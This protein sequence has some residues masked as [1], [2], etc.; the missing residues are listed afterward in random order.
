[1]ELR[2]RAETVSRMFVRLDASIRSELTAI[3]IRERQ[4]Q[5]QKRLR[6]GAAVSVLSLIAVPIGFLGTYFGINSTQVNSAWSIFDM[7]HYWLAYVAA[8]CLAL[9][10]FISFVILN[11]GAWLASHQEKKERQK[12]LQTESS[13]YA[14]A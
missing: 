10:P 4:H 2:E 13:S 11:G 8:G 12:Q 9:V 1:M 3:E 5:E 14:E 6:W 7:N